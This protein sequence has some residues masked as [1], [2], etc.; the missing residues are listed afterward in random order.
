MAE[1][2]RS[3]G[4]PRDPRT[5]AL[6]LEAARAVLTEQGYEALSYEVVARR[7]GVTRPTI[8]RRWPSKV[9]L[10]YE[11]AFPAADL[12][13]DHLHRR[14]EDGPRPAHRGGRPGLLATGDPGGAARLLPHLMPGS[15]LREAARDPLTA[16]ARE[17]FRAVLDQ[18][19]RR[20][21]IRADVDADLIFDTVI[22]LVMFRVALQGEWPSTTPAEAVD[23]I[24]R[25]ASPSG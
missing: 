21:E 11:A 13:S 19:A 16:A 15:A 10:A 7:A 14:P 18:A 12:Q 1:M 2:K 17:Q 5:D 25:G 3:V 8:Y 22:G 6:I 4:R 9:Q 23:L 20:G 24:L